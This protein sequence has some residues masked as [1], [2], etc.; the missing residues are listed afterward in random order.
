MDTCPA[1]IGNIIAY[2]DD[3]HPTATYM[4]TLTPIFEERFMAV[5]GWKEQ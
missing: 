5:T 1:V 3:N 2:L 4:K